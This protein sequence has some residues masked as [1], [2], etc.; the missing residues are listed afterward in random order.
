MDAKIIISG[1]SI[2]IGETIFHSHRQH[3]SEGVDVTGEGPGLYISRYSYNTIQTSVICL[4][5]H[6]V[7]CFVNSTIQNS[8]PPAAPYTQ[9]PLYK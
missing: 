1:N 3:Y 6:T 5:Q 2:V 4:D 7:M 8:P 9:L